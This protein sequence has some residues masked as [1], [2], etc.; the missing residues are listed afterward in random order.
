MSILNSRFM[1]F[2]LIHVGHLYVF[3]L[4]V[5]A[6]IS[7]NVDEVMIFFFMDFI[8]VHYHFLLNV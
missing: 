2:F 5:T 6:I 7:Q 8:S 1:F 4:Y 3:S